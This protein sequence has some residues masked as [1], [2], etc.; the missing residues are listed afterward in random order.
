MQSRTILL[1][2]VFFASLALSG[3]ANADEDRG[4]ILQKRTN[5]WGQQHAVTQPAGTT[6]ASSTIQQGHGNAASVVQLGASNSAGVRQFGR[7]NTGAITQVGSSNT[8]CLIQAGSNLNGAIQQIG[9]NQSSGLLQT[10]RGSSDIPV[11]LCATAATRR[12]VMSYAPERPE[13]PR[14]RAR[15]RGRG[16]S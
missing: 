11:E 15:E 2:A 12:D 1:T 3:V 13:S 10:H 16:A 4:R 9:D 8:A 5:G 14:V 7:D 6:N